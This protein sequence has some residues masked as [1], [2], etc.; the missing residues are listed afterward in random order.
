[1]APYFPPPRQ[2]PSAT[3]SNG[4]KP[5]A[6]KI[7]AMGLSFGIHIMRGIPR[8]SY[9]DNS[10]IANSTYTAKDAANNADPSPW[11]DHMWGVRG[12]TAAG[13]AWYDSLFAQYA[14]WGVDFIKIDDMLNNS[15]KVY[16]QAEVDAIRKAIDKSG[17]A[18][19][20]S[21]SPGPDDPSWLPTSASKL[22]ANANQWRIVKH[23][24]DTGMRRAR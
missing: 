15:T 9:D 1:T 21:L 11:D 22:N 18:I 17:R 13:Q 5:L 10:P 12:D 4:F 2:H 24:L 6:D 3:G 16:H 23:F 20:L 14:S 19:V 8:K 7:H